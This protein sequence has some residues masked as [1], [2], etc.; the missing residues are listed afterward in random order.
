MTHG[1]AVMAKYPP[2]HPR[3]Q[4]CPEWHAWGGDVLPLDH[5]NL[6]REIKRISNVARRFGCSV[7]IQRQPIPETTDE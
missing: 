4:V 3:Y 7:R 2:T 1:I 6:E 5:P